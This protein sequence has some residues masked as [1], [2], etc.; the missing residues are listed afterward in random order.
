MRPTEHLKSLALQDWQAATRHPFTTALAETLGHD[1][2][3]AVIFS[4]APHP[5]PTQPSL[6]SKLAFLG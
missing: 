4:Q 1:T 6:T 5:P 2:L 3:E